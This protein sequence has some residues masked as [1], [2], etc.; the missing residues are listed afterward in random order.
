MRRVRGPSAEGWRNSNASMLDKENVRLKVPITTLVKQGSRSKLQQNM[1]TRDES[2][3]VA[4]KYR[5]LPSHSKASS[6]F[7]VTSKIQRADKSDAVSVSENLAQ[8]GK[9]ISPPPRASTYLL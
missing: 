5:K 9:Q 1:A 3:K 2:Q 8:P 7:S 4:G 6:Y